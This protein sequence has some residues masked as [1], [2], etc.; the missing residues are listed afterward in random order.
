MAPRS[1]SVGPSVPTPELTIAVATPDDD[2]ELRRLMRETPMEGSISLAFAREPSFF[3]ASGVEGE[4]TTVLAREPSGRVVALFSRSVRPSWVDGERR[5][6]AYLSA[7]RIRPAYRARRGLLRAGFARVREL[8]DA[9]PG[10]VPYAITTI[11]SDNRPA[12]RLL[13]AG[14]PGLPRYHRRQDLLTLAAPC[15]RRRY[16]AVPGLAVRGA[17]LG[18]LDDIVAVLGRWGR[19]HAFGPVWTAETLADPERCRDLRVEDF[20]VAIRGGRM[21]GCVALWD[22]SGFKQSV[23]AGYAG[24]LRWGRHAI[25]VAAPWLD[26]PRLPAPGSLLRHAYLSHLAV[27]DDDPSVARAVVGWATDRARPLGL[28]YVTTMLCDDHPLLATLRQLLRPRVYRSTLYLVAWGDSPVPAP[29]ALPH[30]EVA[31]L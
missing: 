10:D 3:G 1:P 31:V 7:L 24:A 13:E 17:E 2:A 25:N 27:D 15:W 8:E 29:G 21:V 23:V 26:V 6:L 20:V 9:H 18:D 11:V 4:S 16:R 22:Q 12:V 30:L 5:D 28:A 14:L 19:R